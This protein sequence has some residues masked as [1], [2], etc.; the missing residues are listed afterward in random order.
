MC[1]CPFKCEQKITFPYRSTSYHFC[2]SPP[3]AKEQYETEGVVYVLVLA[4]VKWALV[5]CVVLIEKN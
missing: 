2:V 4:H 5:L 3:L 1:I